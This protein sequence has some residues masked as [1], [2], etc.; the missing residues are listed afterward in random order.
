MKIITG[1]GYDTRLP[2]CPVEFFGSKLCGEQ[3]LIDELE[4]RAG[5][6]KQSNA[7]AERVISY[8]KALK[9][10]NNG[11]RFYSASLETDP[12]S[13]A[14]TLLYWRDWAILHGWNHNE[15]SSQGR[16]IDL[17]AVEPHFV[18]VSLGLGECIYR[19]LPLLDII[20]TGVKEVILRSDRSSWPTLFQHL[21]D[22][23]ELAK[24]VITEDIIPLIPKAPAHTDL[25]KL[26]I[27]LISGEI[28]PLELTNDGSLRFFNAS[29]SQV[30]A[31]YVTQQPTAYNL[32]IA[33]KHHH[34]IEAA[35]GKMVD[36]STGLGSLSFTRA[37]NYLLHLSLQC[38]WH[39]PSADSVLQYLTLPAG[40]FRRLRQKLARYFKDLPGHDAVHWQQVIDNYVAKELVENPD[41]DESSLRQ[42][43][44]KWL[45][46]SICDS[47][48]V[49]EIECAIKISERIA[50]YWRA[51]FASSTK[52]E[53]R[54]IFL[55]AFD[56]ADAAINALSNWPESNISKDQLSR[57][58]G[59]TLELGQ[60]RWSQQ[61]EVNSFDI[62]QSPEVVSLCTS[63]I[64]HLIWIDPTMPSYVS[65][66]PFSIQELSSIPFAPTSEQQYSHHQFDL[67]R[68]YSALLS[69]SESICLIAI[70]KAPNIFKLLLSEL[71]GMKDWQNLEDAILKNQGVPISLRSVADTPFPGP[72]RW[73]HIDKTKFDFR[74]KESF[75]S[76][77]SLVLKPYE[78]ALRYAAHISEGA[79][80]S[81]VVDDRLKG[82][83][84]HKVVE[85]WLKEKTWDKKTFSRS[86]IENWL[87]E[88]LPLLIRKIALPLAQPGM[89]VEYLDFKQKMLNA[90]DALFSALISAQ[91]TTV[92]PELHLEH[93]SCIGQLEGTMDILC[94]FEQ[95][96][97]AIIDMKWGSYDR[98]REELKAGRPLQLAT[99]AHIAQGGRQGKLVD[100]GY[101][102]LSRSELLCSN[103]LIFST[104]TVVEPDNLSSLDYTWRQFEKTIQWRQNQFK[105][106]YIELTQ[107]SIPSDDR[108]LPPDDALP[109]LEIEKMHRDRRKNNYRKSFKITDPW[110]NLTGNIKELQ[111]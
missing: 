84:A 39:T 74:K 88:T 105:K 27:A 62:I 93:K 108:S 26:Q 53:Y 1:L 52:I 71:T 102:I 55:A 46:I 70:D 73:W 61:R 6:S 101:F 63:K 104:A 23:M 32:I 98:Y 15:R 106:G 57:L 29:S 13:C 42:S 68:T 21:F 95:G 91:V 2:N 37:P 103:K 90:I 9:T 85:T 99:Y 67:N 48:E 35:V 110:R 8:L 41:L 82:I 72:A 87:D 7:K 97:F 17:A 77:S 80:Y 14:E 111:V 49:M 60:S 81:L 83:L 30:A 54:E 34:S 65:A 89:Y 45:P 12:L 38:A 107:G 66:P 100:A 92:Y 31:Q 25:G 44:N 58:I 33:Q 24:I 11:N 43:I 94:E 51:L 76:L 3:G 10:A 79:I 109:V 50:G 18:K 75:S 22:K 96:D 40:K 78:Y 36:T 64:D 19:L 56:A 59:M 86:A 69:A 28:K 47:D 5:L 16:L 20:G 4:F